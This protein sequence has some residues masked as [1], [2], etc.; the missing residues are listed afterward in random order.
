LVTL[1][2]SPTRRQWQRRLRK[3]LPGEDQAGIVPSEVVAEMRRKSSV[4]M[5]ERNAAIVK[6]VANGEA[7]YA[8]LG[9]RFGITAQRVEQICAMNG[10][11]SI[12]EWGGPDPKLNERQRK[13][14]VDYYLKGD[15]A[16]KIAKRFR[17]ANSTVTKYLSQAGIPRRK[18]PRKLTPD[19][20]RDL[21]SLR[22]KGMSY[23]QLGKQFGISAMAA[24][25]YVNH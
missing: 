14:V 20:H 23:E 2:G 4:R 6:A 25:H 19:Q 7:T 16:M 10:V 15:S 8:E 17:I 18:T 11:K 9:K 21:I 13:K 22:K 12:I 24:W 5:S 3:F 1:T